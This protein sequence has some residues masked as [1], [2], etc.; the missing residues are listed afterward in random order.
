MGESSSYLHDLQLNF[1]F[2]GRLLHIQHQTY[3][4][5]SPLNVMLVIPFSCLYS[6]NACFR[7]GKHQSILILSKCKHPKTRTHGWLIVHSYT[8]GSVHSSLLINVERMNEWWVSA[9]GMGEWLPF[10]I[11]LDSAAPQTSVLEPL[12]P[13]INSANV[14]WVA[15]TWK[16]RWSTVRG[17]GMCMLEDSCFLC[18]FI[19]F[20]NRHLLS[21]FYAKNRQSLKAWIWK[22]DLDWKSPFSNL[23][24]PLNAVCLGSF[25]NL[26]DLPFS[27][28]QA[29][30][31]YK[32][33][34]PQLAV[35]VK[36]GHTR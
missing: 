32:Y 2:K 30:G 26:S 21:L 10:E 17:M 25:L 5:Q 35:R 29:E 31:R 11:F 9:E 19:Y 24:L 28:L 27:H 3:P 16:R 23:T 12:P 20:M 18:L 8:I 4:H 14:H 7:L 22:I 34:Y 1:L 15:T 13:V 36:G 6:A 33:Q